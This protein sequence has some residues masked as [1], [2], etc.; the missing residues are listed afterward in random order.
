[1]HHKSVILFQFTVRD[2]GELYKIQLKPLSQT[3]NA[4][5]VIYSD[6]S[7]VLNVFFWNWQHSL[8]YIFSMAHLGPMSVLPI[9]D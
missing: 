3:F 1:M 9:I 8:S 7:G 5:I 4:F 2:S 6:L